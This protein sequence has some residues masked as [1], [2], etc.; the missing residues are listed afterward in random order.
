MFAAVLTVLASYL[1]GAVPFGLILTRAFTGMDIRTVGSGNIGT[2][3][4]MRSAGPAVGVAVMAADIL[5]GALPVLAARYLGLSDWVQ[6]LVGLAAIAGHNWSVYLRFRG[7]KGVATS[8]GVIA[9]LSPA[10]A[11]GVFV[12]WWLIVAVTRFSSVASLVGLLVT[13]L[14]MWW[15]GEPEPTVALA[16]LLAVIG[17]YRHRENLVR[18]LQGRENRLT[19]G[20]GPAGPGGRR[21]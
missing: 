14:A 16:A 18:L 6:A 12:L 11:L 15:K 7:G 13:P 9:V 21:D 2:A 5:K 19:M 8:L 10:V 1:F 3:N 20:H 17:V 4:V